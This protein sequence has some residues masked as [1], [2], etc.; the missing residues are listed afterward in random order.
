MQQ[1]LVTCHCQCRQRRPPTMIRRYSSPRRTCVCLC[2]AAQNTLQ[3]S[4]NIAADTD[5]LT[6][7]DA[8]WS[9]CSCQQDF[10][11]EARLERE[12]RRGGRDRV[13]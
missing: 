12:G 2:D 4:M 8:R 3:L 1:A 6:L 13:V 7:T 9:L 10:G 5:H 11:E